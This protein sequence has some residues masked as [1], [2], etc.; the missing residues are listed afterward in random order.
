MYGSILCKGI[1]LV[2]IFA[3][4][5]NDM[6][7]DIDDDK[8]SIMDE[9]KDEERETRP[10]LSMED[11]LRF[12]QMDSAS[13]NLKTLF[14]KG[15][16]KFFDLESP[17]RDAATSDLWPAID[18]SAMAPYIQSLLM[19]GGLAGSL[20][21]P[22][23]ATAPMMPEIVRLL[24]EERQNILKEHLMKQDHL[25]NGK[26]TEQSHE[27]LSKRSYSRQSSST[28]SVIIKNERS[29][30]GRKTDSPEV[31]MDTSEQNPGTESRDSPSNVILRIPSFKPLA[32]TPNSN[33]NGGEAFS[34]PATPPLPF[35]ARSPHPDQAINVT[36]RT[37]DHMSPPLVHSKNMFSLRDV[38]AKSISQKFQQQVP[39]TGNHNDLSQIKM[40][41]QSMDGMAALNS[42]KR[43]GFTPPVGGQGISVIKNLSSHDLSRNFSNNAGNQS[44]QNNTTGG[45]GTRPKRGKYRNYDRDS[46]VEAVKAVQRG[47]MS[48]HRAG[49]YYGVPHSTLEY[50]VKE[51]HL[52]RPRKREPKNPN[53][54]EKTG[55]LSSSKPNDIPGSGT[56]RIDVK[57][58]V[59]Q[60]APTKPTFPA[61][62]PNGMKMPSMFDPAM[63]LGYNPAP[64]PFWTHPPPFHGIPVEYSP[65]NPG[66][67]GSFPPNA[68][69]FFASQMMQRLQEESARHPGLSSGAQKANVSNSLLKS[70]RDIAEF[71][72]GSA[73]TNGSFLEGIIRSSLEQNPQRARPSGVEEGAGLD[74]S[75]RRHRPDNLL[76]AEEMREAVRKVRAREAGAAPSTPAATPSA[77]PEP[78]SSSPPQTS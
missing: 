10:L 61:N 9:E 24:A 23:D 71:Y 37:T 47:E 43:G 65:R 39:S 14:Q 34:G 50:K 53:P 8:D 73:G 62:S 25:N 75:G 32:N 27:D 38:I 26:Q 78:A 28:N 66:A 52:M 58:K 68:E 60:K 51:R 30:P 29:S 4:D 1:K 54:E 12:S 19:A 56:L 49:S 31:L 33:K 41:S 5:S 40:E 64:F 2:T 63:A 59:A 70:A 67:S 42:F 22:D 48:V 55:I 74:G 36:P 16:Q 20:P 15:G 13:E 77:K 3:D 76:I 21:K 11:I 18:P 44:Q 35:F 57:P 17:K 7:D 45:K 46:L 6:G 69:S 72:E